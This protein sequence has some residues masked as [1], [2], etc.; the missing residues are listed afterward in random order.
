[1]RTS[2]TFTPKPFISPFTWL[3][4]APMMRG[5]S[6][7]STFSSVSPP[8]TRRRLEVTTEFSRARMPSS[9]GPTDW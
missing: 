9:V 5:R 1:M 2:T 8:S 3:R 4:M 6:A 7:D